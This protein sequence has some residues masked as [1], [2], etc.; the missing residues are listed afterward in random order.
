MVFYAGKSVLPVGLMPAYPRWESVAGGWLL[1]LAWIIFAVL[2][3]WAWRRRGGWG[4]HA[5][6]G[7]GFFAL[8]LMPVLG[9]VP[10]AYLRIS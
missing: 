9:L 10:M 1:W 8:N 4:R 5:L 3:A 2:A 7:A 6:L